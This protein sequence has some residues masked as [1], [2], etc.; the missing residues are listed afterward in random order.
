MNS[1]TPFGKTVVMSTVLAILVGLV[2]VVVHGT[3]T[4]DCEALYN[5]YSNTILIARRDALF[6]KGIDNGCFHYN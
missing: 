3:G 1:L 5:E 4:K 2:V 6:Q